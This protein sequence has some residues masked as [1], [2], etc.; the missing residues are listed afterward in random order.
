[1]KLRDIRKMN[2]PN[3]GTRTLQESIAI[4]EVASALAAWQEKNV[5]NGVLIGGCAVSYYVRPRGTTDV[6]YLSRK[7][8]DI[9]G[10]V[11]GFKRIR[12]GAFEHK[13][14]GV[15]VEVI[16]PQAINLSQELTQYVFKTAKNIG[17]IYVASPTGLVALK[18]QRM[19]RYDEG[20]IAALAKLGTVDLTDCPIT[21]EQRETYS[22]ILQKNI[23]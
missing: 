6:D 7:D 1:M 18:L 16:S 17:G 8:D 19:K 20:D 14:T 4:P 21:D 15:E 13:P 5:L 11:V 12:K 3:D 9:P 10:D 2:S 23:S 22:Q